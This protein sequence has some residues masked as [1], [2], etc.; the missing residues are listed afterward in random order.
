[1]ILY[2]EH[3]GGIIKQCIIRKYAKLTSFGILKIKPGKHKFNLHALL[4]NQLVSVFRVNTNTV[5][6]LFLCSG[7]LVI[8]T[9]TYF[10]SA[11]EIFCSECHYGHACVLSI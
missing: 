9:D 6:R 8:I 4:Y 7:Y 3:T 10:L 5:I 11:V 1:M 2:P